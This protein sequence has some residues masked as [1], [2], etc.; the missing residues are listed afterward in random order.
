MISVALC[1]Y[2]GEKYITQQL[3]SIA[4]QSHPV[5]EIVVCDDRSTDNTIQLVDEFSKQHPEIKTTIIIN[6]TNIGVRLNFEKA[7]NLCNGDIKFLSDQDDIWYPN[8]VETVVKYFNTNKNI[9]VVFTNA[10][11]IDSENNPYSEYDLFDC[12]GLDDYGLQLCDDGYFLN[13]F[14]TNGRVYGTTMAIRNDVVCNFNYPTKLYHDY[15]ISIEA[16]INNSLGYIR[17]PLMHYRIHKEQTSGI[18]PSE[19][20][21]PRVNLYDI[22]HIDIQGYPC[23]LV[24]QQE[25][26]MRDMRYSFYALGLRGIPKILINYHKYKRNY[27]SEWKDYMRADIDRIVV[28]F[29]SSHFQK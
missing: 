24:L 28:K 16:I 4:N 2:N 10:D 17:E 5:D 20:R 15:I 26:D 7:L 23:P 18:G 1:T 8:K 11:L 19:I 21:P 12:V 9:S 6:E 22:G 25:L 29:K 27:K 13:I 14:L 3:E